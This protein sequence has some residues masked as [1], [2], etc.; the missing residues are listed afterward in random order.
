MSDVVQMGLVGCGGIMGAHADGLKQLWEKGY[1]A[2][3]IPAV[4]DC[5]SDRAEGM[6]DRLAAFQGTRPMVYTD[7]EKMLAAEPEM[8]AVDLT[9]VH[10]IHHTI[11]VP[12][13]RAGKHVTI[14][15]PLAFTMRSCHAIINEAK[16]QN[17][18]LQVAENYR[19]SPEERAINW[20]IEQGMI[21]DLRMIY[22]IDVGE[23]L[24]HWG[25]RD[26][27][28][29]AGG[30]WSMDG[31]VHF[32]DLFRYHIGEVRDL[33]AVSR[34][35]H[36]FR[37]GNPEAMQDPIPASTEDTTVAVLNFENGVTG[38]WTSTMAAPGVKFSDRVVYG[39]E[40]AI[41]WGDGLHTRA[42]SMTMDQL[43]DLY[44]DSISEEDK[45]RLF[46][47]GVTDTFATELHEFI[48]AVRGGGSVEIDGVQGMK[49]EAISLALYESSA[50]SQPV[51]LAK[52]ENCEIEVYQRRFNEMVGL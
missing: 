45:Q 23:R 29:Q 20:A 40:G 30:G 25:W 49:D 7:V 11:A 24:F 48:E 44:L 42:E 43:R 12:C 34:A 19:R 5:H 31:G 4:C 36:P 22:W 17:R 9:L 8:D 1:H 13:L 50:V 10:R 33:Y 14:E 18:I 35:Y 47:F 38:Q 28:D 52:I 39:D 37:Y 32:A 21:G 51:E 26:E 46:P 27:V 41:R 15:K 2:F 3:E 6:A 16:R